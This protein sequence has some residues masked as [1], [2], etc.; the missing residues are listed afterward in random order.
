MIKE[1]SAY[2]DDTSGEDLKEQR[3]NME[4]SP[5]RDNSFA[6]SVARILFNPMKS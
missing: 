3:I 4:I 1:G 5:N 6:V 2:C